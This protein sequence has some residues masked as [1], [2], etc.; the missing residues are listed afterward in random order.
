MGYKKSVEM[1]GIWEMG[2]G[3]FPHFQTEMLQESP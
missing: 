3:F 1:W 2:C